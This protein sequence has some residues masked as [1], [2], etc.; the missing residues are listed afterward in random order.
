MGEIVSVCSQVKHIHCI[1]R[2]IEKIY[3]CRS[4]IPVGLQ[5]LQRGQDAAGFLWGKK[6]IFFKTKASSS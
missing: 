2:D 3:S 6:I 4:V 5:G 1:F